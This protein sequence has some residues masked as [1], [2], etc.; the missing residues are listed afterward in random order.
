MD[1]S[2][3][4]FEALIWQNISCNQKITELPVPGPT[5]TAAVL[6][7]SGYSSLATV[8]ILSFD[9][10]PYFNYKNFYQTGYSF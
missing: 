4:F 6:P 8:F 9:S 2:H 7:T 10:V 5:E 1:K 3:L